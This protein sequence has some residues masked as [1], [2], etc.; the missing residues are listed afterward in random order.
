MEPNELT[1]L[2][3]KLKRKMPDLYRHIVG[4]IKAVLK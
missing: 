4:M 1:K 3:E 2:L